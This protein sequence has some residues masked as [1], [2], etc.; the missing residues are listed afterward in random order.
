MK[1]FLLRQ[2][3][4]RDADRIVTLLTA[5]SGRLDVKIPR[6]RASRKRFGGLDLFVLA[7]V[8]LE[9]R[10]APRLKEAAPLR[11]FD[12]IR[13]DVVRLGLASY[14][15]ELAATAAQAD[16]PAPDLFRLTEAAFDSLD[17]ADAEF[18]VGGLG[19]ARGFELKLLH[20]LGVRP[21]LRQCAACGEPAGAPVGWSVSAGGVLSG[22]CRQED[23]LTQSVSPAVIARLDEALRRPLKEQGAVA[24]ARGEHREARSMMR[25]FVGE[26]VGIRERALAFLDQMVPLLL[27]GLVFV[28]SG[29]PSYVPP[30]DVRLQGWLLNTPTPPEDG[31]LEALTVSG[32]T[33]DAYSDNGTLLV[34]GANPFADFANYWRFDPLP[35]ETAVHVV[36]GPPEAAEDEVDYVTTVLSGRTALEDL[37]VD[38]GTFHL[39]SR[40]DATNWVAQWRAVTDPTIPGPTFDPELEGEGG[41]AYG[42]VSNAADYEGYRIVVRDGAGLDRGAFYTDDEGAPIEGEGLSAE[43]TFVVLGLSP[44]PAEI[45]VGRPDGSTL[46]RSFATR[47]EEDGVTSLVGFAIVD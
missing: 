44:G 17:V 19:W 40:A 36:F 4:Y 7:N 32:A 46:E 29:C 18:D 12:G 33:A 47:V 8:V 27:V 42:Q 6:A 35:P 22:D 41:I 11:S 38:D 45:I 28:L 43:G 31:T 13:L 34:E 20:V 10:G 9:T 16:H 24:W 2:T 39:W 3:N 15:A 5:E 30:E 21:S 25:T 37:F 14:A 23:R 26:H 1:A